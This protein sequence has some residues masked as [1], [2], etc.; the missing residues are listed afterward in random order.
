MFE[1]HLG[2]L[3]F[4]KTKCSLLITAGVLLSFAGCGAMHTTTA[5]NP[6]SAQ[7]STVQFKMGDAPADGVLSF[8]VTV[9]PVTLTSDT[10][11]TDSWALDSRIEGG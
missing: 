1:T 3:I 2:H 9:G 7:Q 8:E 4:V 11:A 6:I 5:T 10:G